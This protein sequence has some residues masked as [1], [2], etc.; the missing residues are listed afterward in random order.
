MRACFGWAQ[1]NPLYIR[2]FTGA[3]E[4]DT[5]K[6]HY[7]VHCSLDV[8]KERREWPLPPV[9]PYHPAPP[10]P[11]V[12]PLPPPPPSFLSLTQG[13]LHGRSCLQEG[14]QLV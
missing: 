11:P 5:A 7:T 10:T 8:F 14:G 4:D 2:T 6:F 13:L 1:N 3:G 9:L 12:V